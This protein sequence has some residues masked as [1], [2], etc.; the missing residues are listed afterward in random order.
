MGLFSRT[1]PGTTTTTAPAAAPAPVFEGG[2][3][4]LDDIA[5]DYTLDVAH[6]RIGFSARHAMVTTVR[7]QFTDFEG[8]AHL[9]TANPANVPY[10][11]SN[12]FEEIG[13]ADGP[14]GASMWF[15]RRP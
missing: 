3:T 1:K 11:A 14:R 2:S 6:T 13:K 10:Y 12:G 9:D 15:M 4:A 5:G 7:G 8:T